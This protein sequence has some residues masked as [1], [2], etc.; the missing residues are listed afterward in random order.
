MTH[1][2]KTRLPFSKHTLKSSEIA[3]TVLKQLCADNFNIQYRNN[4]AKEKRKQSSHF[5]FRSLWI[6]YARMQTLVFEPFSLIA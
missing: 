2:F 3:N 6:K 1:F 5:I 4:F